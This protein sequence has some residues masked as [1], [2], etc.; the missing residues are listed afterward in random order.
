MAEA[1]KKGN[2]MLVDSINQ[3]NATS[4]VLEEKWAKIQNRLVDKQIE[5]FKI[6]DEATNST[7]MVMGIGMIQAFNNLARVMT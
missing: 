4:I 2:K 3:I 5:Y 7:Q 6:K 1:T